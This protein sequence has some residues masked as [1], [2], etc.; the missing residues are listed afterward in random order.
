MLGAKTRDLC[1]LLAQGSI[2][3][4]CKMQDI[5]GFPQVNKLHRSHWLTCLTN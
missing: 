2:N 3:T 5:Y 4:E 1:N